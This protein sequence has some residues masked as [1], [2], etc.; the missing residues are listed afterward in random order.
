MVPR[1][2]R[3]W[4]KRDAGTHCPA[5]VLTGLVDHMLP[6]RFR[7]SEAEELSLLM[8]FRGED[9]RKLEARIER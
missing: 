7:R 4:G 9:L 6:Q 8:G 2:G 5:L 1:Q 3:S